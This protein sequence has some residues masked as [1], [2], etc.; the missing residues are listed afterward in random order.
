M[1]SVEILPI[2]R[3][4]FGTQTLHHIKSFLQAAFAA[5]LIGESRST[6]VADL[7]TSSVICFEC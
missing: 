2:S 4:Q 6:R 5:Q 7:N 1:Q 3:F